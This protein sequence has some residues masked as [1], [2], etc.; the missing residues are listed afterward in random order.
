MP[1]DDRK[2]VLVSLSRLGNNI[3][4][5]AREANSGY[6]EGFNPDISEFLQELKLLRRFIGAAHGLRKNS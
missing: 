5:I 1:A 2:K 3:N 4:Q 6:R